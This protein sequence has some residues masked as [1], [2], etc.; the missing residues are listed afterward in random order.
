MDRYYLIYDDSCPICRSA[1]RQ[2]GALDDAGAVK[3]VPLSAPRLPAGMS[4]PPRPELEREIH[5]V[6]ID[7]STVT[8][9][10]AA[11]KLALLLPGRRWVER[12]LTAPGLRR[13]AG[14]VYELIA[15]HRQGLSKLFFRQRGSSKGARR[16]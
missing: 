2:L 14:L 8:G 13:I 9:I 4:L 15:G 6:S 5:L 1:A 12:L 10:D 16:V 11:A 3:L 7:G